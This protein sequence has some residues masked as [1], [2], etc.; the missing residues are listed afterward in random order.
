[1]KDNIG[2]EIQ[3]GDYLFYGQNRNSSPTFGVIKVLGF[4]NQKLK[5]VWMTQY[6]RGE[7][8]YI[9][10]TEHCIVITQIYKEI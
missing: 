9:K 4:T 3:I 10:N 8:V 7:N 6:L 2:Q 5:G 1:M